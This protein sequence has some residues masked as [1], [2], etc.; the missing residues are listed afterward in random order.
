MV[1]LSGWA[2]RHDVPVTGLAAALALLAAL[3]F[4]V[5]SAAQQRAASRV[6]DD[7]SEG[8]GLI[9]VLVRRP[10]WWVGTLC[11]VGGYLAQAAALGFGSL[12]L[13]QPLLVAT[14]LMALPLSARWAGRRLRR[15]DW[16]WAVLLAAALA[17]FVV[18]G[19]PTAGLDR[20]GAGRW[21]P[22]GIVLT[23]L[24]AGCL[25]VAGIRRQYRAVALAAATA[26]LY[27]LLAALT[28]AVVSLL[29]GG[30]LAVLTGWETY[31]LAA[32]AVVGTVLQQSAFQA[33]GLA[34]SLPTITVG[35]PV[36]AVAIGIAVL[37]EQLR[38]G[39]AEWVL[40]GGLAA[41][42]VAA[43]AALAHSAARNAPLPAGGASA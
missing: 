38:S 7:S 36:V 13:V 40:I 42:M 21:L 29:A 9:K 8:L 14:L 34:A 24:L 6:S 30:P 18:T 37:D 41:V 31:A 23:T 1:E 3:F 5:A 35:E 16:V 17:V 22:A 28:K 32:A 39:G 11:D 12:L 25:L 43:T 26:L 20:A 4:A 27:G 19:E 2:H 33:G 10:L 15:S